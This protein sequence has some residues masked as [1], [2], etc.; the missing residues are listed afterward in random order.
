MARLALAALVFLSGCAGG[1]SPTNVILTVANE[2]AYAGTVQ[3]VSPG[4]L[5]LPLFPDKGTDNFTGCSQYIRTF[6]VGHHSISISVNSNT[7]TLGLDGVANASETRYVVVDPSGHPSEVDVG[8]VP[9][10]RCGHL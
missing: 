6:G 4:L 5:G 10:E 2:S 1:G 8:A 9:T 7:L 3:W